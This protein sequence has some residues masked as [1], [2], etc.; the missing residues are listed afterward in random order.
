MK[1]QPFYFFER[2]KRLGKIVHKQ[3][4]TNANLTCIT[5]SDEVEVR[6]QPDGVNKCPSVL[7]KTNP[8]LGRFQLRFTVFCLF[9]LKQFVLVQKSFFSAKMNLN[10]A[11][12]F[13]ITRKTVV[14]KAASKRQGGFLLLSGRFFNS[15]VKK[16]CFSQVKKSLSF[17]T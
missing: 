13:S 16:D 4:A 3:N 7:K 6:K 11:Q 1:V 14:K 15:N 5:S 9:G 12:N 17:H 8:F 2:T 10:T